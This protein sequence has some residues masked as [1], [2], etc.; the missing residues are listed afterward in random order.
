M[1]MMMMINSIRVHAQ[2]QCSRIRIVSFF[3]ISKNVTFNVFWSDV[4]RCTCVFNVFFKVQKTWL[5][6][7]FDL[8]HTFSRTDGRFFIAILF[9]FETRYRLTVWLPFIKH[10]KNAQYTIYDRPSRLDKGWSRKWTWRGPIQGVWG[11]GGTEVPQ[12]SPGAEP[13]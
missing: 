11:T 3:L 13:R 10:D 4:F 1:S 6:T 2:M 12:R 9:S 7:F 8:L 5:F